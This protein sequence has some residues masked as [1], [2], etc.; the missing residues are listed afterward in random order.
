[1][2]VMPPCAPALALGWRAR[3]AVRRPAGVLYTT[4]QMQSEVKEAK[5]DRPVIVV[6]AG[7]AGSMMALLLGKRGLRVELYEMRGDYRI[8]ERKEEESNKYVWRVFFDDDGNFVLRNGWLYASR[9]LAAAD[10]R[11]NLD[12]EA[13]QKQCPRAYVR[14]LQLSASLPPPLPP[15]PSS[16]TASA[17]IWVRVVTQRSAPS[18][19]LSLSAD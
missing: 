12:N 15:R 1:M 10:V 9:L 17:D 14:P 6:G 16:L 7:L 3:A 5:D 2:K 19:W 13:T 18:T 8:E 4:I 11:W